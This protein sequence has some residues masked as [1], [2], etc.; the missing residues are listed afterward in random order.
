MTT[1]REI[2]YLLPIAVHALRDR[3]QRF[4][5]CLTRSERKK[6]VHV[7]VKRSPNVVL[8]ASVALVL[9]GGFAFAYWTTSG[10][11]TGTAAS[12]AGEAAITVHQTTP[13]TGLTPGGSGVTLAG[14]YDNPNTSPIHVE[15]LWAS[16]G[17]ITP[18][19]GAVGVCGP[20][21]YVIGGSVAA[22]DVGA[23]PGYGQGSWSGLTVKMLDS[24]VNQNACKGATVGIN[25]T[26]T[27]PVVVNPTFSLTTTTLDISNY[28]SQ[29]NVSTAVIVAVGLPGQTAIDVGAPWYT[30][31]GD[32]H[33]GASTGYPAPVVRVLSIPVASL[34]LTPG[35]VLN[36]T[37]RSYNTNTVL[38]T[39]PLTVQ[40]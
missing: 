18:A 29:A 5:C 22:S 1:G 3:H 36:V 14:T 34:G 16:I 40:P 12:A 35:M 26:T 24:G 17:T 28:S 13:A 25:Y 33:L 2:V 15:G 7:R 9:A 30:V 8:A 37:V 6:L 23:G 21:N 39:Y 4:C 32:T 10:T 38:I 31:M 19:A 20:T 11:G 27:A